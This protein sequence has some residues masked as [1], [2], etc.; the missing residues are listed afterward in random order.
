MGPA[1]LGVL[2]SAVTYAVQVVSTLFRRSNVLLQVMGMANMTRSVLWA[3]W[4][5]VQKSA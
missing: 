1:E 3:Q 5:H 2:L 4:R